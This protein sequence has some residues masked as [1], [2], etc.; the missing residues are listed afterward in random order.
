MIHACSKEKD[1]EKIHE[2]LEKAAELKIKEE[3][4]LVRIE[5]KQDSMTKELAELRKDIK[6]FINKADTKYAP[7][8]VANLVY[9]LLAAGAI[10][11]LQAILKSIGIK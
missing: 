2:S 9:G 6:E 10:W 4:R 5:E 1:I 11:I 7:R 8:W 3:G